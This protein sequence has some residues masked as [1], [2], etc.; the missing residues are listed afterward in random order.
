MRYVKRDYSISELLGLQREAR[1]RGSD[2]ADLGADSIDSA[3][4]RFQR[5]LDK[6]ASRLTLCFDARMRARQES[7]WCLE[8]TSLCSSS[9][10]R[11]LEISLVCLPI[12]TKRL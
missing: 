8:M 5:A 2:V 6:R 12:D 9:T 10:G 7:S 1:N 4:W 11:S 3:S